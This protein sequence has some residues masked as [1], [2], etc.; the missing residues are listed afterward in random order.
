MKFGGAALA[1]AAGFRRVVGLVRGQLARRPVVV[2]SAIAGATDALLAAAAAAA[3]GLGERAVADLAA[4]HR[5]LAHELGV[6]AAAVDDALAQLG[7]A[8]DALQRDGCVT[9]RNRDAVLAAGER[10]SARLLAAALAAAGVPAQALDAGH[11]GFVTDSVHGA[12]TPQPDEPRMRAA[13]A[14][15][16]GVPVVEGFVG[17]D[18]HGAITTLG[19]NGSDWSA[20]WFAAALAADEL[21]VWKDVAGV[22]VADPRLVPAAATL[23]TLPPAA[24]L[25]LAACGA[26][27]VHPRALALAAA[28]GLPLVVRG[29]GSPADPGTRIA[30]DAPPVAGVAAIGH[31]APGDLSPD[32]GFAALRAAARMHGG[33]LV[34]LVG[35]PG[36]LQHHIAGPAAAALA[37]A[38]VRVLAS[39]ALPDGAAIAFAVPAADVARSVA[40]LHRRFFAA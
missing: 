40:L 24:A 30:A 7:A 31:D 18:P 3:A 15:A 11:A 26:R 13:I 10:C 23:P 29:V 39:D 28:R 6:G 8:A 16:V 5:A 9:P 33:A 35:Q 21:Q 1:D 27:I 36:W 4:R 34:G 20:A 19:R 32:D 22:C 12:A 2:V 14:A 17:R 37:V 25:A 38:G